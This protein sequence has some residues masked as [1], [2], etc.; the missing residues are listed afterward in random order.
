[1]YRSPSINDKEFVGNLADYLYSQKH[2]K[3][4]FITGDINLH[5]LKTN[6]QCT[7]D[8][9]TIMSSFGYVSYINKYTRPS[10][11]TCIDHF[12]VKGDQELS[13][14]HA[15]VINY[16][17]TDHCPI[18][19]TFSSANRH[20]NETK[21]SYVFKKYINYHQLKADVKNHFWHEKNTKT[22]RKTRRKDPLKPWIIKAILRCINKK[23]QLYREYLRQPQ[24]FYMKN[25]YLDCKN[26]LEKD[27]KKA[28][29]SYIRVKTL[30]DKN[31]NHTSALW[32]SVKQICNQ[33]QKTSI[34]K[35]ILEDSKTL[36]D[37]IEISNHFNTFF[38][39]I[40]QK[41]SN[42]I[43]VPLNYNECTHWNQNSINY[44]QMTSFCEVQK[45]IKELKLK[46]PRDMIILGQKP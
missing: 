20:K 6:N 34:N 31:K 12:Y 22:V 43:N 32:Q 9:K 15:I 33:S 13:K 5:I 41:L 37:P 14:I 21:T 46:S 25:S 35:I 19:I 24:N 40:G 36:T 44:F 39:N 42:Q 8:S 1:M 28:K 3:K 18:L 29:K 27:I 38:G 10:T 2:V 4:H 7:E 11:K 23:N 30:I 17:I 26:Q 16:K 45:V